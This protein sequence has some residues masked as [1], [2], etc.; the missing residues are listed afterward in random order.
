MLGRAIFRENLPEGGRGFPGALKKPGG[1]AVSLT[2]IAF[3][4]SCNHISGFISTTFRDGYQVIH[5]ISLLPAV[6]ASEVIAL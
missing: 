5:S 1:Y 2:T 6:M 3:D 4:T